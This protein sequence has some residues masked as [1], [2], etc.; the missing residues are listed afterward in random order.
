MCNY[1]PQYKTW[2]EWTFSTLESKSPMCLQ[3]SVCTHIQI[4]LDIALADEPEKTRVKRF[5][6]VGGTEINSYFEADEILSVS[7]FDCCILTILYLIKT[8]CAQEAEPCQVSNHTILKKQPIL[9]I[10]QK[11]THVYMGIKSFGNLRQKVTLW[12][13]NDWIWHVVTFYWQNRVE[14]T[15]LIRFRSTT[16][17]WGKN[18]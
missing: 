14:T 5:P 18:I 4:T 2:C 10:W 9:S 16:A 17:Q 7:S 11:L 13:E 8:L 12:I 6:N 3:S 15:W 1:W